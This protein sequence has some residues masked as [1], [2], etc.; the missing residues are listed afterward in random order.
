MPEAAE[1]CRQLA[2]I[3][4][5]PYP[6]DDLRTDVLSDAVSARTHAARR[7]AQRNYNLTDDQLDF[8][9]NYIAERLGV[10]T[11]S[12]TVY[13][14]ARDGA[15]V[16]AFRRGD[17]LLGWRLPTHMQLLHY[18]DYDWRGAL[19]IAG[20]QEEGYNAFVR[21]SVAMTEA[22]IRFVEATD[23]YQPSLK[24]LIRF[25]RLHDFALARSG[26]GKDWQVR[27]LDPAVEEIAARGLPAPHP[28]RP[29]IDKPT[30]PIPDRRYDEADPEWRPKRFWGRP[31]MMERLQE[32][33]LWLRRGD[34]ATEDLYQQWSY[35]QPDRPSLATVQNVY[36]T[37]NRA[38]EE[39]VKPGAV[40]R[41]R[42][43][44][45]EIDSERQARRHEDNTERRL[46]HPAAIEIRRVLEELG[47]ATMQDLIEQ[48][49]EKQ[50]T[51]RNYLRWL[52]EE[53]VI[54][55]T[56][57]QLQAKNQSY[58]LAGHVFDQAQA[59]ARLER[60]QA[61]RRAAASALP[62]AVLAVLA[63]HD[64]IAPKQIEKEVGP[65]RSADPLAMLQQAGYVEATNPGRKGVR[66]WITDEGRAAA[67]A[68]GLLA[69]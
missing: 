23:G 26:G 67:V 30:Y 61:R 51:L 6:W 22:I 62:R 3:A 57:E 16:E 8:A 49:G 50:H 27:F 31:Q 54:E 18:V 45:E 5:R 15:V 28:Y 39:A 63:A 4:G 14:I 38:I 13:A 66:Y 29:R 60:D 34:S 32:F 37:F 46:A 9:L 52:R 35:L 56:V 12:P 7:R 1:I 65:R 43:E 40:D 64:G 19:R 44:Q 69:A 47:E 42:V 36:G 2:D 10:P 17:E 55:T 48:T 41:A 68:L 11:L 53:G 58:R 59:R 25:A 21:A 33:L 24:Q 20:L